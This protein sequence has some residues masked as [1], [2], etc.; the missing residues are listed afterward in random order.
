MRQLAEG[1]D[2]PNA[3]SQSPPDLPAGDLRNHGSHA[4][5]CHGRQPTQRQLQ[6]V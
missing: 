2:A 3:R 4:P 6:L 5:D 1:D